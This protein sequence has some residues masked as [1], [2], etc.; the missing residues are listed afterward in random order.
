M[1]SDTIRNRLRSDPTESGAVIG[2]QHIPPDRDDISDAERIGAL[3]NAV[4]VCSEAITE[5][6]GAVESLQRRLAKTGR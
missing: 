6:A 5:L 4:R 1:L 2:G 3:E